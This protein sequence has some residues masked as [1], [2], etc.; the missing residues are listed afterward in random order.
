MYKR[1]L[2]KLN[3]RLVLGTLL[4]NI[5]KCIEL[6]FNC[7]VALWYV[8]WKAHLLSLSGKLDCVAVCSLRLME[9]NMLNLPVR[10]VEPA[11]E[12]IVFCYIRKL[13]K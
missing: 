2:W 10:Q 12:E 3:P 11:H 13:R 1:S 4:F 8:Y 7:A 6:F 9:S 5:N